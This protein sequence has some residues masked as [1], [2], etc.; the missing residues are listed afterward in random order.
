MELNRLLCP[1]V[2]R[3]LAHLTEL[4]SDVQEPVLV[5]QRMP[6]EYRPST[7]VVAGASVADDLRRWAMNCNQGFDYS[8]AGDARGP[9]TPSGSF[10]ASWIMSAIGWIM[11]AIG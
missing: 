6:E 11:S 8:L 9:A 2:Y 7:M 3:G 1:D 4:G 5:L 10:L